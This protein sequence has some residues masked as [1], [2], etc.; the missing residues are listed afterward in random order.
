ML[1]NIT[2]VDPFIINAGTVQLNNNTY[3]NKNVNIY[4]SPNWLYCNVNIQNVPCKRIY[5]N[6]LTDGIPY[7]ITMDEFNDIPSLLCNNG[8][9][10]QRSTWFAFKLEFIL[11][12]TH[13]SS[14]NTFYECIIKDI[15]YNNNKCFLN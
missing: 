12:D 5:P 1:K 11:T 6:E 7:C 15:D 3:V 9:I 14:E 10:Y 4:K 2:K 8:I 13:K